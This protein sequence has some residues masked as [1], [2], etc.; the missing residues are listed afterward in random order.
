MP[1]LEGQVGLS[2]DSYFAWDEESSYGSKVTHSN[3][4]GFSLFQSESLRSQL[5]IAEVPNIS[6]AHKNVNDTYLA[7]EIVEGDVTLA[8]S[9]E[10][11]EDL[12]LHAFGAVNNNALDDSGTYIRDFDL[13]S[14]GRYRHATSPSLSTHVNRGIVGSGNTDPTIFTYEGCVVDGFVLSMTRDGA[15]NLQLTFFGQTETTAIIGSIT[16]TYPTGPVANSTECSVTWGS[17]AIPVTDFTLTVRR[18]IDRDRFF[19]GTTQTAEPPMGQYEVTVSLTTEWDDENRVGSNSLQDDYRARTNRELLLLWTSTD[20]IS[21][22]IAQNYTCQLDM[23]QALITQFP[24]NI[25]QRG[26]VL[27]PVTFG[28]YHDGSSSNQ[29]EVRLSQRTDNTYTE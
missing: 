26:R 25:S 8:Y 3:S 27:V 14:K 13:T 23:N 19:F 15:L 17:A 7:T 28:C 16:P 21:G 18:N 22:T 2:A 24:P 9:Y 29:K 12:L 4:S 20:L 5:N 1:T 10:G 6:G 11:L